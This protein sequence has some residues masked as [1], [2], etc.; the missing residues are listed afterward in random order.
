M[1]FIIG[2]YK[3]QFSSGIRHLR[4]NL[5]LL[6]ADETEVVVMGSQYPNPRKRVAF[7][8]CPL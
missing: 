3:G 5:G 1:R 8:I 7:L 2:T 4:L 6:G